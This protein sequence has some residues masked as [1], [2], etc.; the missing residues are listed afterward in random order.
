MN[1]ISDVLRGGVSRGWMLLAAK[2]K[3]FQ[4]WLSLTLVIVCISFIAYCA[5][6]NTV[7]PSGFGLIDTENQPFWV[8]L[9]PVSALVLV[10]LKPLWDSLKKDGSL[11]HIPVSNLDKTDMKQMA[12]FMKN[13]GRVTIYSG[14]FSYIYDHEPLYDI[15]ID[16]A[17]R[18]N[19]TFISYKS[20]ETVTSSSLAKRGS[21]D[22]IITA[23]V[24]SNKIFFDLSGEA[25]FSLIYRGGEEIL[26]YK[27]SEMGIDHITIFQAT[28]GMSKQLVETIK[29]LVDV[30]I[31]KSPIQKFLNEL[32]A[33]QFCG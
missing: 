8:K 25:K 28:N 29:I 24:G 4:R 10:L 17:R 16:L 23:L 12:K 11:K 6:V 9:G 30:A 22:C 1:A 13:A 27:H 26:L 20:E 18:G 14:D 19:L 3:H 7:D 21:K 32:R 31:T 2:S 15:L 5:W 33:L